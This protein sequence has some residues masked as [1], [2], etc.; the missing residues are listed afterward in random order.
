MSE[1]GW[2][3]IADTRLKRFRYDPSGVNAIAAI[4]VIGRAGMPIPDDL[5]P[6]LDKA[7]DAWGETKGNKRQVKTQ[8]T[9]RNWSFIISMVHSHRMEGAD[10]EEAIAKLAGEVFLSPDTIRR[11][12][13]R[14]EN[15]HIKDAVEADLRRAYQNC[16]NEGMKE[17]AEFIASKFPNLPPL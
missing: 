5:I 11:E 2:T 13:D 10:K 15:Q 8:T 6:W 7:C 12:Y 1:P 17:Q 4:R 16:L 9:A 14:A 3:F